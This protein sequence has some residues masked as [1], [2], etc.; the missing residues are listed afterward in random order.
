MRKNQIAISLLLTATFLFAASTSF[1]DEVAHVK[2]AIA[3][4]QAQWQAGETSMTQLNPAERMAR[5]GLVKPAMLPASAEMLAA[6]PPPVGAP[7]S[8]DWRSNGGNFVTPI[9]DQ[10][11]CGSCWAFATTAALESLTLRVNNTPGVDLNL[12]EQVLVSCGGAGSC[13]GGWIGTASDYIRNTGL[14]METCYPYTETNGSCG[15]ACASYN[16]A[17]YRIQGWS[18]VTMTSPTVDAIRNALNSY[19]PLVTTLDVYND[20]FSYTSGVYTHTS[21]N[22]AGGHAVLIVGY[23]DAGQYFIVKNSWDT[24]WGELGYF[25]IAYSE[26]GTDVHFGEYTIAYT[27]SVCSYSISPA[28]QSFSTSGGTGTVSVATQ[29]GCTWSVSNSASWITITAGSSGTG[30]GNV[31]YTVASNSGSGSRSAVLTIGGQAFT[32]NESG[33]GSP[34]ITSNHD[35][36]ADG[37]SDLILQNQSTGLLYYWLMNGVTMSSGG[38]L[39]NGQP[40]SSMSWIL[41]GI[42]DLN[43]DGKPDFIWQNQSTGQLYYWLMNGVTRSGGGYLSPSQ[44]SD[45]NWKIACTGDFNSDGQPDFIWQNQSTGQLYYW[46]MNGVTRSSGGYLNPSKTSSTSWKIAGCGDLNGDGKPDIIWQNQ[47]TGQLYYWLMNGVTMSSGGYLIPSKTSDLNWNI[48][49]VF[50]IN[51]DGKPDIVW[52]NQS[53]GQLY[54]WLMNGVTMSSGGYLNNGQP[55]DSNWKIVGK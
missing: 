48:V 21:G 23:D 10:G 6:E 8:L 30:S 39:N 5:L 53:T 47:S 42:A 50:D 45:L 24:W 4:K 28:S 52:E 43:A 34:A 26:L 16:S 20:F 18:W 25:K 11:G 49:G 44:T 2:A 41:A 12:S 1:A 37:K 32:V 40:V 33:Q 13:A 51:G 31:T 14:P 54:Y 36:N 19:G 7:P 27:G 29:A 35:F 3:A 9:R 46:L 17:T 38:Y 15:S 55:I 22:Y